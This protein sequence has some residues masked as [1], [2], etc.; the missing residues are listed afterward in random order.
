M[1]L[2]TIGCKLVTEIV[3]LTVTEGTK[4]EGLEDETGNRQEKDGVTLTNFGSKTE[5]LRKGDIE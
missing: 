4:E 2:V 5:G 3:F 1:D